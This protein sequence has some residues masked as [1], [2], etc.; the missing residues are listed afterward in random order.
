MESPCSA[1]VIDLWIRSASLVGFS[2]WLSHSGSGGAA[3]A[4]WLSYAGSSGTLELPAGESYG[5]AHPHPGGA[6]LAPAGVL[7]CWVSRFAVECE[8]DPTRGEVPVRFGWPDRMRQVVELID[9]WEGDEDSYFRVRTEDA[10]TY[11]LRQNRAS[12]V[13]Q[14]HFFR[15]GRE[16]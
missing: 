12:G 8:R 2:V 13:W 4:K 3:P 10:S 14:I 9:R 7:R 6:L 16:T 5:F 15:R 1:Q 11:I